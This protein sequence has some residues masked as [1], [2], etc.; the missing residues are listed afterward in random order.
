LKNYFSPEKSMPDLTDDDS[1]DDS[2]DGDSQDAPSQDSMITQTKGRAKIYSQQEWVCDSCSTSFKL[3][4]QKSEIMKMSK[5]DRHDQLASDP[6]SLAEQPS[7]LCNSCRNCGCFRSTQNY[8]KDQCLQNEM[9]KTIEFDETKNEF[10]VNFVPNE[11][12]AHLP[13]SESMGKY[14][15]FSLRH[16]AKKHGMWNAL[17][18][19]FQKEAAKGTWVPNSDMCKEHPDFN[20]QQKGF[21]CL[22]FALKESNT[23]PIR[24]VSDQSMGAIRITHSLQGDK[25]D[26]PKKAAKISKCFNSSHKSGDSR[27]SSLAV[28]LSR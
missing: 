15:F 23:T 21:M 1:D 7:F 17:K 28:I 3:Y 16:Q 9:D 20:N 11:S 27:I 6:F 2:D 5:K 8:L 26:G 12:L 4:Q 13:I 14:R 18:E 10:V 22:G 24:I 25:K 19:K